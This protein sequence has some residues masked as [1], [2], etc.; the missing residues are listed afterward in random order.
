MFGSHLILTNN[1]EKIMYTKKTFLK[2]HYTDSAGILF[3]SNIFIIAHDVYEEMTNDVGFRL[4]DIV[5]NEDFLLPLVHS[6]ADYKIP[7][8]AGDEI[9][10]NAGISRLGNSSYTV[11]FSILKEEKTAATVETVMVAM[12]KKSGTKIPVPE[13]LREG[14]EKYLSVN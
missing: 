8:K 13:K 6:E 14:L 12:D 4:N 7:L 11:S 2:F 5:E 9:T 10:I 1:I 3:F